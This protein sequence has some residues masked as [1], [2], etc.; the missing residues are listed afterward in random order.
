MRERTPVILGRCPSRR[1]CK[2]L[3]PRLSW[4]QRCLDGFRCFGDL[5]GFTPFRPMWVGWGCSQCVV[6]VV[7]RSDFCHRDLLPPHLLPW[8]DCL[9]VS[10][11]LPLTYTEDLCSLRFCHRSDLK[12][13]VPF[14]YYPTRFTRTP[15]CTTDRSGYVLV[16]GSRSTTDVPRSRLKIKWI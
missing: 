12:I 8:V 6:H 11:I 13:P 4:T 1:R 15:I 10:T 5:Q 16:W 2:S 3:G 14:Q 7:S 9:G